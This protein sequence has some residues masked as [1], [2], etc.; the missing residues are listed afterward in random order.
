MVARALP[1][2]RYG[3][4]HVGDREAESGDGEGGS[5]YRAVTLRRP[6][7]RAVA[8]ARKV[9]VLDAVLI[10]IAVGGAL[11]YV[12]GLQGIAVALVF[13]AVWLGGMRVQFH[14]GRRGV[15]RIE[16]DERG[17]R[18]RCSDA[19][20]AQTLA[21][22]QPRRVDLFIAWHECRAIEAKP[23]TFGDD[24]EHALVI[25]TT[26]GEI[27]VRPGVFVED[28]ARIAAR[29]YLAQKQLALPSST[30]S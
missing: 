21:V 3:W 10:A 2:Y 15:H 17:I 29:L 11:S 30:A 26:N 9:W 14:L 18:L 28:P 8:G 22:A 27:A 19:A 6:G 4:D 1:R 16:A 7:P 24:V 25:T 13:W 20:F 5:P 23:H 12:A